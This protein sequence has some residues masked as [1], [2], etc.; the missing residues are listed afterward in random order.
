MSQF[1]NGCHYWRDMFV[2]YGCH[3]LL[4]TGEMRGCKPGDGCIRRKP[5]DEAEAQRERRAMLN[6]AI[7]SYVHSNG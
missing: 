4:I 1:C 5:M 3:Y 7:F 2:C 6:Q